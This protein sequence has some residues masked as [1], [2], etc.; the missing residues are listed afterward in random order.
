[1]KDRNPILTTVFARNGN[2]SNLARKLGISR[3]AVSK[4][5]QIPVDHIHVIAK[6]SKMKPEEL[7]PDIFANK[8]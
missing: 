6:M 3:Q 2:L 1:M 5:K 4:W 8:V 7:R